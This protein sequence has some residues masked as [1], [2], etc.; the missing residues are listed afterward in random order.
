MSS[1]EQELSALFRSEPL[2]W[3]LRGDPFLWRDMGRSL[4]KKPLPD[5]EAQLV[6]LLENTFER[7]TGRALPTQDATNELVSIF[8]K[9]Y[10]HGGMSSGQV[11]PH[12]WRNVAIP[13][14][15]SRYLNAYQSR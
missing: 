8:V 1:K 14:L 12:F 11:S 7:L 4:G 3:G 2:Q 10:T 15:L 13:L 9:K 6:G 5:T